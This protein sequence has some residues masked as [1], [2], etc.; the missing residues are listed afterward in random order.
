MRFATLIIAAERERIIAA[1][2]PEIEKINAHIKALAVT[3][4]TA[5]TERCAKVAEDYTDKGGGQFIDH[6]GHGYSIAAAIRSR[7]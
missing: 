4:V 7:A 2:A 1:N 6:E 3:A 5:E